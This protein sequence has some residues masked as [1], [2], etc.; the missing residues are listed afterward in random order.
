MEPSKARDDRA[1]ILTLHLF[2]RFEAHYGKQRLDHLENAKAR[3]LLSFLLINDH[4][5]HHR[6]VLA[7]QLW[8]D[9][10]T[11]QSRKYLRQALWQ[12]QSALR[13]ATNSDH[14]DILTIE[15]DWIRLNADAPIWADVIEFQKGFTAT[16]ELAGHELS[17]DKFEILRQSVDLYVSDLLDGW[18]QDWC[19]E[20]R[21]RLQTMYVIMVDKLASYCE[22]HHL[23][24]LGIE[25]AT[26]ILHLDRAHERTHRRLIRMHHLSGDRTAALRQY[27]RCRAAL[28]QELGIKP[29]PTTQQLYAELATGLDSFDGRA[30]RSD[31]SDRLVEPNPL[32]SILRHLQQ[33]Q[34]LLNDLQHDVE[35]NI[36]IVERSLHEAAE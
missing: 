28:A 3:E 15:P 12:L 22:H 19:Q 10:T 14:A 27:E 23:Y 8:A 13:T 9:S 11:A 7:G 18:Y 33:L 20:E 21:L 4:R 24:E 6:E 5:P 25:Y 35:H 16:R 34:G 36:A 31:R 32:P 30:Q 2:G 29:S 17:S 1:D 26:R